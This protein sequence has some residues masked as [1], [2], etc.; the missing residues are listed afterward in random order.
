MKRMIVL[1]IAT[2]MIAGAACVATA[3]ECL[4]S[5]IVFSSTRDNPAGDPFVTGEIYLI[6]PDGTN[7]RRLTNDNAADFMAKLST[8]GKRIVFDSNRARV[9]G[10]PLN[11]SDLF[12]KIGR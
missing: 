2:V 5:T 11:T 8:D 1:A 4:L 9:A 12:L 6:D 10:E 7:Q 3:E